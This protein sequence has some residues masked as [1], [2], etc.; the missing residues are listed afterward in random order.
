VKNE[1]RKSEEDRNEEAKRTDSRLTAKSRIM[2]LSVCMHVCMYVYIYI[3]IFFLFCVLFAIRCGN[4]NE[5]QAKRQYSALITISIETKGEEKCQ[6]FKESH[7]RRHDSGA[8]NPE[9]REREKRE[10]E[11]ERERERNRP[12]A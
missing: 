12:R 9:R 6:K 3:Y 4:E 2:N 7:P 11:R 10:R 8:D 5:R 1:E